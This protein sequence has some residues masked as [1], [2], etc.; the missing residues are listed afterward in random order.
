M[1]IGCLIKKVSLVVCGGTIPPSQTDESAQKPLSAV[2]Q[3]VAKRF[4][5]MMSR[6][7]SVSR[8]F[9]VRRIANITDREIISS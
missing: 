2:S 5:V 4:V 6:I 1:T 8:F 9:I 3:V 7:K